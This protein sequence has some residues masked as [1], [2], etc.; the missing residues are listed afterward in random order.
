MKIKS[1]SKGGHDM[2]V[3][4]DVVYPYNMTLNDNISYVLL[5]FY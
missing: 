2:T 3:L 1:F 4:N 5:L